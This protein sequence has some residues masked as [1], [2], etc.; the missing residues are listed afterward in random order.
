MHCLYSFHTS[1]PFNAMWV[2]FLEFERFKGDM[3]K[4]NEILFPHVVTTL[5]TLP[6]VR[7]NHLIRFPMVRRGTVGWPPLL[8]TLAATPTTPLAQE[9][10]PAAG[11]PH[12]PPHPPPQEGDWRFTLADFNEIRPDLATMRARQDFLQQSFTNYR[13]EQHHNAYDF[14]GLLH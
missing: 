8:P 5:V 9:P 2:T 6:V 1:F 10:P 14:R 13:I 11:V 12:V 4:K 3:K 7:S